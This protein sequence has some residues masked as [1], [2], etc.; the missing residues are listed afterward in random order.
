METWVQFIVQ[1][2]GIGV[3]IYA[4]YA[5]TKIISELKEVIGNHIDHSTSAIT[6][7]TKVIAELR[8]AIR[9]HFK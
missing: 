6:E 1:A 2:G 8:E 3:A 5:L 9:D 7:L 4:I